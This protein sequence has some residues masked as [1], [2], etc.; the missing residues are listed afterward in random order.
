MAYGKP[1]FLCVKCQ[2]TFQLFKGMV[3]RGPG[4]GYCEKHTPEKKNAVE[5]NHKTDSGSSL[6]K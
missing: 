2:C 4:I 6:G 3:R 5:K 1:T